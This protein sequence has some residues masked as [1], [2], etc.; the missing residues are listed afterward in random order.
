MI[1]A[2]VWAIAAPE[3]PAV[4]GSDARIRLAEEYLLA[5]L[6]QPVSRVALAEACGT[7]IRSLSRGF[8]R[9][10]GMGRM[11]FLRQRRLEA[12]RSELLMAT[13][14]EATVTQ[15]AMRYG[16]SHPSAFAAAYRARFGES[17]SETLRS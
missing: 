13:R 11:E 2:L 10:Q 12:A 9:R 8:G 16:F 4:D 6:D 3:S 15:V 1:A 17:P 5:H 14:E 7:S